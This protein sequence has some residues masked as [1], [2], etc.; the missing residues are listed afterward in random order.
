MLST[1]C[2][3]IIVSGGWDVQKQ[4]WR[5]KERKKEKWI[6]S[7]ETI[8]R[9]AYSPE[10]ESVLAQPLPACAGQAL[11]NKGLLF[12]S[13][14][15]AISWPWGLHRDAWL[16]K[17]KKKISIKISSKR[18]TQRWCERVIFQCC[19]WRREMTTVTP[20]TINQTGASRLI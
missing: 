6:A 11:Q 16:T 19:V 1:Y 9:E 13:K 4:R 3:L 7:F 2:V 8:K 10:S 20:I 17:K 18:R 15:L 12:I 5:K 14:L